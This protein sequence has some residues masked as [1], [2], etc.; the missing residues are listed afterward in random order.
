MHLTEFLHYSSDFGTMSELVEKHKHFLYLLSETTSASQ[1]KA[2][3]DTI[4]QEQFRALS[5]VIVNALHL[6]IPL[7]K[8]VVEKLK[9][10]QKI[11]ALLSNRK[12]GV[13]K[14][15]KVFKSCYNIVIY[16]LK[17][18]VPILKSIERKNE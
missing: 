10:H 15:L 3:V 4:T 1:R 8:S 16:M 9:G 2:L 18:T 7:A 13:R 11:F 5:Q 6:N 17:A 12:V 14:R